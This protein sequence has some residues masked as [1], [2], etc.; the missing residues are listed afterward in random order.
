MKSWVQYPVGASARCAPEQGTSRCIASLDP[1]AIGYLWGQICK[2]QRQVA[3]EGL[4]TPQG[5]ELDIQMDIWTVQAQWPG[6][7]LVKV[8]RAQLWAWMWTQN[9]DF[10]TPLY[11]PTGTSPCQQLDEWQTSVLFGN[12]GLGR[13]NSMIPTSV[14]VVWELVS[15]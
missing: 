9:S 6:K 2:P 15:L 4:Y 14:S 12:I 8:C 11:R 3:C 1:G 10:F 5:V 13:T 7:V